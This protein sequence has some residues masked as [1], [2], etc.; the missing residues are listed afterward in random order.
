VQ[1]LLDGTA[2]GA[3]LTT[4]P[5]T[6]SWDSTTVGN[7]R[8]TWAALATDAAGQTTTSPAVTVTVNNAPAPVPAG[9]PADNG[10]GTHVPRPGVLAGVPPVFM[11][12]VTRFHGIPLVVVLDQTTGAEV[13]RFLPFPGFRGSVRVAVGDVNGDRVPEVVVSTGAGGRAQV[14]V[15]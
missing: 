1:F 12:L 6:F 11:P 13:F 4:A 10:T 5:Y 2:Y 14:G 15:F 3:P 9:G 8:H 7:G